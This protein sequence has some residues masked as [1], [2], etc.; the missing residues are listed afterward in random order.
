MCTILYFNPSRV[1]KRSSTDPPRN[2]TDYFS[3]WSETLWIVLQLIQKYFN[4]KILLS[5]YPKVPWRHHLGHMVEILNFKNVTS[6]KLWALRS[7][8]CLF[9]KSTIKYLSNNG[10]TVLI[11]HRVQNLWPYLFFTKFNKI[12]TSFH[13]N[14]DI[15]AKMIPRNEFWY[16]TVY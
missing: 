7:T 9:L 10:S 2:T 15:I 16:G 5:Y 6:A 14:T 8:N 4:R 13:K 1:G 3:V 12:I 11:A